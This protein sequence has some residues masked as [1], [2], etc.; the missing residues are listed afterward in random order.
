MRPVFFLLFLTAAALP[1]QEVRVWLTT[2][3]RSANLT[4]QPSTTLLPG[5]APSLTTLYVNDAE[6]YQTIDGFG[7]SMTDS[8]AYLLRQKLN[9]AKLDSVLRALFHPT[10]GIGVEFLRNPMGA[11]DLARF[12]YSY[13]D[14][15][16]GAT[17]PDLRSFSIDHDRE[18][19]LPLLRQALAINPRI[20]MMASPWSAPGWMKST[21]S[22]IG[23]SL[24]AQHYPAFAQ[25]FIKYLQAYAAE[26]V[27][28]HYISLQN[29]PGYLPS[30]YPGMNMPAADQRDILRDHV[31]PALDASGHPA[32]VLLYDWNWDNT[33]YASTVLAD[34]TL[35]SSQRVAGT[36]W[37][38]YGGPAGA[39]T[40]IQNLLPSKGQWV[41]EAS[42]GTWVSSEIQT[43]FET[44]TLS[45]RSFAKSYVKWGLALDQNRGPH[46]GGCGTCTPLVTVNTNTG[47]PT[48]P[49]DYYTL[50]H[51]SK[52]VRSGA[53]RVFSTNAPGLVSAAFLN[54]D[55]TRA[56][57]VYNETASD[58]AFQ[59]VT[60]GHA[61]AYTLPAFSGAT[62][63]WP[64]P[65]LTD[66]PTTTPLVVR[67][68]RSID[69]IDV[70]R[71]P[72]LASSYNAVSQL[73][74]ESCTDTNLGYDLGFATT[75]SWAKYSYMD[76][77]AGVASVD[78]RV[79]S[80]GTGGSL[81]FR[82]DS[83]DGPVI[84][85]ADLPVTGGWQTWKTVNA[86]VSGAKGL[87]TL[88]VIF[89]RAS[90]SGGLGN[91]NWF[92]FK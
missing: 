26:G 64:A 79:A 41:T 81:E 46:T 45:M 29:E 42:G 16:A 14:L 18:D 7:A 33:S 76:F 59:T 6:R 74:A 49:I 50:G 86:P 51:F 56:L 24:L 57:V 70:L 39:M 25:Y 52:F 71:Q 87:R 69:P 63:T 58:R 12:I 28:V 68:P 37:H 90:G 19:I 9:P 20:K 34:K 44:I 77:G 67:G 23:G 75:G 72:I 32:R 11:S 53:R 31:I 60:H 88:Y 65:L 21:G 73:Q 17:D 91:L 48:Y 38:W 30:D 82:L 27:P 22:M 54:P 62:F 4:P 92:Q 36:A 15:S 89:R 84:A 66:L 2:P 3:D 80:A 10:E 1:A 47:E 8:S 78:V 35:A 13:D 83:L 61:F 55:G 40:T 5:S 43:D 85:T